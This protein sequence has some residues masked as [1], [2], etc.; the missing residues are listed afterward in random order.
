[1][2]NI[3]K[4]IE[5]IE[6][7]TDGKAERIIYLNPEKQYRIAKTGHPISMLMSTEPISEQM[8]TADILAQEIRRIDGKHDL[9]AGVLAEKLFDFITGKQHATGASGLFYVLSTPKHVGKTQ[10]IMQTCGR[11]SVKSHSST[12]TGRN[13]YSLSMDQL[14]DH[15]ADNWPDKTYDL[16]EICQRLLAMWPQSFFAGH[17]QPALIG[18]SRGWVRTENRLPPVGQRVLGLSEGAPIYHGCYFITE[19]IGDG[20][21]L[22]DMPITRWMPLPEAPSATAAQ[23]GDGA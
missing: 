15:I 2:N 23:D 7:G 9:G 5:L 16:E 6:L 18:D 14:A 19:Y 1:V 22:F 8:I 10:A 17:D 4:L 13:D 11:R 20:I 12:Q 21:W 3:P